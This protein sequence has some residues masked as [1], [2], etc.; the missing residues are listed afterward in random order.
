[1]TQESFWNRVARRGEEECWPWIGAHNKDGYGH[2]YVVSRKR[3]IGAHRLSWEIH[4]GPIPPGLLVCHTC[5]NPNCVNP[6]H[7][8]L[9]TQ[10]ENLADRDQKGRGI[11]GPKNG[12]HTHPERTARGERNGSAKLT[13][14]MVGRILREWKGRTTSQRELARQLGVHYDTVWRVVHGKFWKHLLREGV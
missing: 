14:D 13:G 9:G 2:L 4:H 3:N 11:N 1:M 7:L 8:F 5:D 12:R 6:Y 10:K